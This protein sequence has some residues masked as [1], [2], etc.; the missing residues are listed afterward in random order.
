MSGF[1]HLMASA[2]PVLR[3]LLGHW[4]VTTPGILMRLF[5][6]NELEEGA[7]YDLA[8]DTN[9]GNTTEE[10]DQAFLGLLDLLNAARVESRRASETSR[11]QM[12]SIFPCTPSVSNAGAFPRS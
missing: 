9:F 3:Q 10:L 7:F 5:D 2:S 1:R 6:N 11:T 12:C 4:G 8:E